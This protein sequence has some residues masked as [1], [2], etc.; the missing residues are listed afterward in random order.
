MDG[1]CTREPTAT[2]RWHS[3]SFWFGFQSWKWFRSWSWLHD[4]ARRRSLLNLLIKDEFLEASQTLLCP[5]GKRKFFNYFAM[6][7]FQ[8]ATHHERK[9]CSVSVDATSINDDGAGEKLICWKAFGDLNF[10]TEADTFPRRILW[11]AKEFCA[12]DW[13][14]SSFCT[15]LH[16]NWILWFVKWPT[17]KYILAAKVSCAMLQRI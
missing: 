8:L 2:S 16:F 14:H 1:H 4:S 17:G 13:V 7:R 5:R 12:L 3:L 15:K 6:T 9:E 11:L 10:H